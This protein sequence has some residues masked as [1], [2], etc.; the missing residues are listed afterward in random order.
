MKSKKISSILFWGIMLAVLLPFFISS[1]L[2][3]FYLK[4]NSSYPYLLSFIKFAFLATA[5]E[6]IASRIRHGEYLVKNFGLFPRAVIWGLFGIWIAFMMRS[7]SVGVPAALEAAGVT[8]I[9]E[10]MKG[11]LTAIKLLGAFSISL[12]MNS[13]FAPVFM[14]LHK[15]TDTHISN[16]NGSAKALIT[17]IPV[18]KI[19][20][21]QIDW[22][23]QW[24]FIFKKTIPLF[25]IPAH[26]ITFLLPV[27]LQ[28]LFAALLGV[29]LGL[30][31]SFGDGGKR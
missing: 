30:I 3:A 15:V 14:T 23:R 31:L 17:P 21:E 18:A 4:C 25:W 26:T 8:G 9:G 1:D 29:F 16:L 13:S 7:F 5:G 2:Y 10:A 20:S 12:I 6:M 22:K 11:G 28:V 27:S 19:L 24:N